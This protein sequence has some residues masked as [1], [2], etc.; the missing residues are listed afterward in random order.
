MSSG[1]PMW[2]SF[3]LAGIGVFGLYLT[4][5]G[6]RVRWY[7][8]GVGL[9][10]QTLWIAY[11]LVTGQPGFLLSACAFGVVNSIGLIK[12]LRP[13]HRAAIRFATT[14]VTRWRSCPFHGRRGCAV[15]TKYCPPADGRA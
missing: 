10:V 7:G 4:T 6:D 3:L 8:Y 2:W 11:A 12:W 5:L 9:A 1:I 14:T 15:R 13:R